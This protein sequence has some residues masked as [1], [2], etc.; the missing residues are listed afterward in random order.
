[1]NT[2]LKVNSKCVKCGI[3]ADICPASV[4]MMGTDGPRDPFSAACI[5]CGHCV[6]VCPNEAL[7]NIKAPLNMQKSLDG[8]QPP[9][10]GQTYNFLRSRRS[11]RNYKEQ[12][13]P[14]E[15]ILKLLDI[16]R[17]APTGGNSQGLSYLV[18][19]DKKILKGII[20]NVIIW[21]E[22]EIEKKTPWAI[23]YS[24]FVKLYR[25][26]GKDIVLRGAPHLLL[27]L[28]DKAFYLGH[29]NTLFSLEYAELY[30]VSMGLGTCWA[31]F[32]GLCA[33]SGYKPLYDLLN[34]T[35]NTVITGGLMLGY[36]KYSYKR[37]VDRN[38]LNVKWI[39]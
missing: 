5:A 24:G 39:K 31:G 18:V 10:P 35:D 6:A 38:P 14:D 12:S 37:L 8:F 21:M 7:D 23:F 25:K 33:G 1:M 34:I 16:S 20:E 26:T 4:I 32:V 3:C 22:S 13:V 11:I 29:D 28:A 36:P 15:I 2:I 17:F 30:A 19:S 9:S 27:A